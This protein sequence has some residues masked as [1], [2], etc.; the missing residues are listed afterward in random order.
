MG[1]HLAFINLCGRSCKVLCLL[2]IGVLVLSFKLR[3]EG[4]EEESSKRNATNTV[5]SKT[6][7]VIN[8][9]VEANRS[10]ENAI[11]N[12]SAIQTEMKKPESTQSLSP[13]VEIKTYQVR[14][15]EKLQQNRLKNVLREEKNGT[16]WI[17]SY[18]GKYLQ[19]P[20]NFEK[21]GDK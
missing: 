16:T 14:L 8:K 1:S 15:R 7:V 2:L 5:E 3:V 4:K 9:N 18:P 11:Q 13:K 20:H 17:M 21:V 12:V 19:F 10:K 6:I